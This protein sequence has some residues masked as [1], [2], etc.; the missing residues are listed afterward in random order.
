MVDILYKVCAR[1]SSAF[2]ISPPP[3]HATMPNFR[4]SG[5]DQW[6]SAGFQSVLDMQDAQSAD[7]DGQ[8][9][10]GNLIAVMTFINEYLPAKANR[11][12]VLPFVFSEAAI[13]DEK[14][15]VSVAC[16]HWSR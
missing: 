5:Y 7:M 2:S 14:T 16:T 6:A 3:T 9:V 4:P 12:P 13:K 10:T 11:P 15:W 8:F 1:K